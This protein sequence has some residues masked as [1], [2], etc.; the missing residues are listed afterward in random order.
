MFDSNEF[1]VLINIVKVYWQLLPDRYNVISF[2][3]IKV[4]NANHN[5]KNFCEFHCIDSWD[6]L[7]I[8][9]TE[10][11]SNYIQVIP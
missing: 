6:F 10:F 9:T 5:A 3:T 8:T 1:K 2:N 7:N 4:N 11:H